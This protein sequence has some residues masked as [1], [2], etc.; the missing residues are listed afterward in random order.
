MT[1]KVLAVRTACRCR[2]GSRPSGIILTTTESEG[3]PWYGDI[4]RTR[5]RYCSSRCTSTVM[6][7]ALVVLLW[8]LLYSSR[9]EVA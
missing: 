1:A 2:G 8:G 6:L 3:G 4:T 9:K 7:W 5:N